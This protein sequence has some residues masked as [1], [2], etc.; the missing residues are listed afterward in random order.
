LP[1]GRWSLLRDV[2]PTEESEDERAERAAWR[3]LHRYGV[4]LRELCARER[5]LPSWRRILFAL[6]RLE[7]RGLVRGGRFVAGFVGEQFA[8]PEALEALRAIRRR[9]DGG[10]TVFVSAADPLNLVGIITPGLRI[11]SSSGQLIAYRAG[12][13][14]GCGSRIDLEIHSRTAIAHQPAGSAAPA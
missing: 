11:P 13:M 2:Q 7:A 4:L 12:S 10:E 3:L 14:I 5:H 8:L 1:V 9:T 6:R